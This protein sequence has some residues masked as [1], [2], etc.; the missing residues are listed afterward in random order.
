MRDADSTPANKRPRLEQTDDSEESQAPVSSS[1]K[2][3]VEKAQR[4]EEFWFEDGNLI[5]L[6]KDVAFRVF[7]GL[8]AAQS[9]IFAGMC[10][11]SSPDDDETYEGCPVVQLFDSPEDL[12]HLLRIL[13]PV[14]NPGPSLYV[15]RVRGTLEC[16]LD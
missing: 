3:L 5:L 15:W 8:L 2:Q 1:L 14:K 9:S 7:K 10:T 11:A 6:A 16:G 13:I 12:R 4:D